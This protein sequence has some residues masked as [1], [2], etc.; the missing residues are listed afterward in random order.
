MEQALKYCNNTT[1]TV[2]N[3]SEEG[4][5]AGAYRKCNRTEFTIPTGNL[6]TICQAESMA[7]R[8]YTN[9]AN[10]PSNSRVIN[11]MCECEDV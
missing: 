6:A 11:I 5:V 9:E 1:D 2:M 3:H 7:T 8:Q 4:N 10:A